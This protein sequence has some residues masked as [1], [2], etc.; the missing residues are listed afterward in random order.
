MKPKGPP[1]HPRSPAEPARRRAP[2]PRRAPA[3]RDKARALR[4]R[5]VCRLTARRSP[6]ALR[7]VSPHPGTRRP[8][9]A[10]PTALRHF[11]SPATAA[12]PRGAAGARA[13][14]AAP[15]CSSPRGNG[16]TPLLTPPCAPAGPPGICTA[17]W[18]AAQDGDAG[19]VDAEVGTEGVSRARE[20]DRGEGR[21]RRGK[22]TKERPTSKT[23]K[24]RRTKDGQNLAQSLRPGAPRAD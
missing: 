4:V 7:R 16:A 17:P 8:W 9:R 10:H 3:S 18:R 12:I 20:C 22:L 24:T 1:H 19:P 2:L 5:C 14:G 11:L 13:R 15:A 6:P 23:S 21:G